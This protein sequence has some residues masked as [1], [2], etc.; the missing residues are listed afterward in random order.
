MSGSFV[1]RHCG[2][3]LLTETGA[4][5]RLARAACSPQVRVEHRR[6]DVLG[7]LV[8]NRT[9][10]V[11]G[12]IDVGPP[13]SRARGGVAQTRADPHASIDELH[14]GIDDA[15]R[16]ESAEPISEGLRSVDA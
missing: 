1:E 5:D 11:N 16:A 6:G 10:L 12:S 15:A 3:G 8:A 4:L 2:I 13:K 7:D 14:A 9:Q